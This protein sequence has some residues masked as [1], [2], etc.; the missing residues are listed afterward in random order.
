M[1]KVKFELRNQCLSEVNNK[2]FDLFE[3]VGHNSCCEKFKPCQ[4]L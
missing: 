3:K 4:N 1:L 2:M